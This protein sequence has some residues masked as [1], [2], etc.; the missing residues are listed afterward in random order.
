MAFRSSTSSPVL[1]T[2]ERT[3]FP[4][5]AFRFWL[6][7]NARNRKRPFFFCQASWM[8]M[9]TVCCWLISAWK[10]HEETIS[11]A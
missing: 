5:R 2:G 8:D 4:L 7:T 1:V 11:D 6:V 9:A 3:F 10:Y